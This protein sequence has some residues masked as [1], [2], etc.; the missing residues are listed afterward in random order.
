LVLGPFW[1]KY[2]LAG[3]F[4]IQIPIVE[5]NGHLS[6]ILYLD[7]EDLAGVDLEAAVITEEVLVDYFLAGKFK[8]QIQIVEKNGHLFRNRILYFDLVVLGPFGGKIFFGGKIQNSKL[9]FKL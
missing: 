2:F 4:K 8:S 7:L 9:K 1:G 5:K 6:R 3:K